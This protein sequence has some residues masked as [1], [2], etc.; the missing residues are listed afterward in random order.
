[1]PITPI[2]PFV[3]PWAPVPNVTPFTYRDGR[4]FIQRLESIVK[5]LDRVIIP[6]INDNLE[7]FSEDFTNE[8]NELITQVNTVIADNQTAVNDAITENVNNVNTAIANNQVEVDNKVSELEN[9]VNTLVQQIINSTIEVSDPVISSVLQNQSS[10]TYSDVKKIAEYNALPAQSIIKYGD[11]TDNVSNQSVVMQQVIDEV[12]ANG[13]GLISFPPVSLRGEIVLKTG[14]RI[15]GSSFG[16][17]TLFR[18]EDCVNKGVITIDQTGGAVKRVSV[19][20]LSVRGEGEDV[21]GIY[22][23]G[24]I[25]TSGDGGLWYSDFERLQLDNCGK[26]GICMQGGPASGMLP[27]QFINFR[28]IHIQQR[29]GEFPNWIG[30]RIAGQVGQVVFDQLEMSYRATGTGSTACYI[31]REM[32]DNG[33]VGIS[34]RMPYSLVFN[35]CTF[36]GC[37][38][39]L[40]I[41]RAQNLVF[42]APWIEDNLSGILCENSTNGIS[43]IS[44]AI[45]DSASDGSGTGYAVKVSGISQCAIYDPYVSG[46]IDRTWVGSTGAVAL[47]QVHGDRTSSNSVLTDMPPQLASADVVNTGGLRYVALAG[48]TVIN[49]IQSS[50]GPGECLMVKAVSTINLG[51]DGNINLGNGVVGPIG[52][53]GGAHIML[54]KDKQAN[55]FHVLS[56]NALVQT[57]GAFRAKH[58]TSAYFETSA[59]DADI[60]APTTSAVRLYSKLVSGKV[61]LF[62]R[63][64]TGAVQQISI[65]P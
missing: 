46:T 53:S 20:D 9:Q 42:N 31:S 1:M 62:A 36:Q 58:S 28:D 64:P 61:A 57:A 18:H 59:M 15:Q 10:V 34:D 13:G 2:N 65:E 26:G 33:V 43:V 37:A 14:V 4:T 5:Y 24:I 55:V 30:L 49:T 40:R 29:S 41:D 56:S 38:L 3:P 17:S 44:P 23:K 21:W 8:I 16:T 25:G 27:Q 12:A 7:K 19:S 35:A 54:V 45:M 50:V 11:I 63:F 60:N 52:Y 51:T 48:A 47:L 39:G 32:D 22:V 6:F